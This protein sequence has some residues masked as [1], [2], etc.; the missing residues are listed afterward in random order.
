MS[1]SCKHP[2]GKRELRNVRAYAVTVSF[3]PFGASPRFRVMASSYGASQSHTL[4]TPHSV[5]LLRTNDQ[6]VAETST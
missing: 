6:P 2:K 4:D 5:G 3:S 1:S